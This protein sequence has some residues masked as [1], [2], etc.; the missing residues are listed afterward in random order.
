MGMPL[1][2]M[3]DHLNDIQGYAPYFKAAFPED[4]DP[5]TKENVAKA[6]AT[7]E[8]TIVSAEAPFDKWIKGDESAIS[9]E[10]KKGFAVFNG[11]GRCSA[12][13]SEWNFSDN[14]FHDIGLK[15]EDIGR[16]AI[17]EIDSMKHAFKTP[18]LRNID[19]RGPYMHDGSEATLMDVVNHYNDGFVQRPSLSKDIKKLNLTEDE[20]SSLVAF[21]KTLTSK[22]PEVTL[23]VLPR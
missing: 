11:K 12:C 3:I 5:I 22:D 17:L 7:Y 2:V 21:M 8:R 16:Y 14:S 4:K 9:E 23:P 6:I 15:S 10:A 1:T 13:H 20:K 18:G 19:Q